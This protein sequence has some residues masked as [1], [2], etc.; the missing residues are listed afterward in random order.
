MVLMKSLIEASSII[1]LGN[2]DKQRP[3]PDVGHER[4][5]LHYEVE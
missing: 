2:H 1:I 3:L 4:K 5:Q